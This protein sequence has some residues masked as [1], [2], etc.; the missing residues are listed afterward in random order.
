MNAS[1]DWFEHKEPLRAWLAASLA[2]HAAVLA[3]LFV[4][5][6][7]GEGARVQWGTP[8]ALGGGSVAV[9]PVRQIPLPARSGRVNPVAED[10]VSRVPAP[11][12]PQTRKTQ[13]APARDAIE[14]PARKSEASRTQRTRRI[15]RPWVEDRPHQ[16]YSQSGQA[17]SSPLFGAQTG[18]G[19]VGMGPGSSFGQRYGWY[20]DLIETRVA[21]KWDTTDV[22]PRLTSAP[23]VIVIFDILRSGQ[24][25]NVAIVQSS[26]NRA[27]DYSAQRAIYLASPFPPLPAG[28]ERDEA[29]VEIWFQLKR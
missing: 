18:A 29:R 5:H 13:P 22:D 23:P 1:R 8:H 24:V 10:T 21:Q 2:A 20:R 3:T 16:L 11:P 7:L 9:T 27:L 15:E 6:S 12:K 14:I 25:R 17:L 4:Y 26:G 19:G 28:F